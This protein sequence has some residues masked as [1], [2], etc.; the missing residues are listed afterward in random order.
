MA[1]TGLTTNMVYALG[2][3]VITMAASVI[4]PCIVIEN[5]HKRLEESRDAAGSPAPEGSTPKEARRRVIIEAMKRDEAVNL[6]SLL[7][8]TVAFLPILTLAST[9]GRL[10]RPLA[11]RKTFAMAF[12]SILAVTA[13][14]AL[15]ALLVKGKILPERK[16]IL[17]RAIVAAYVPVVRFVVRHRWLVVGLA[18]ATIAVTVPAFLRLQNEFMPPL[19]ELDLLYMPTAP[20]GMPDAVAA[21]TLS[22]DQRDQVVT[23]PRSSAVFGKAGR[24]DSATTRRRCR[25]S[26]RW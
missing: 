2:G 19:E 15:V 4:A 24:A 20:A 12:A 16:H 1:A 5:V 9:E 13:T 18:G 3:I 8:L 17:T 23:C 25:C 7:V 11:A 10:F 14:P 26:R 6:G 22:D 21:R